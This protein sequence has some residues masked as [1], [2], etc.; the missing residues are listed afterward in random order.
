[1]NQLIEK[2]ENELMDMF[3]DELGHEIE[4]IDNW[5]YVGMFQEWLKSQ[6]EEK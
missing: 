5:E 1:M 2:N 3:D 6:M 4:T